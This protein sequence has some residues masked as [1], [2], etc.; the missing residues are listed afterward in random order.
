MEGHMDDPPGPWFDEL[1][2][3]GGWTSDLRDK[4][5]EL[6]TGKVKE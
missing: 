4:L 1:T 5:P 6:S 3:P 2:Q